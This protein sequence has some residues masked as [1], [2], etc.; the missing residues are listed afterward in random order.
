MDKEEMKAR[1]HEWANKMNVTLG[2][3]HLR[4]MKSKWAS[5]STDG[6]LTMDSSILGLSEALCDYI[7]VHELLHFKVRNHGKLFKSLMHAYLPE[8]EDLERELGVLVKGL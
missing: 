3:I 8:W 6:R 7:I 1:V 4:A 2:E 5:L